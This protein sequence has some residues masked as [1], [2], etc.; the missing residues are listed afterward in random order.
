MLPY[1]RRTKLKIFSRFVQHTVVHIH[2]KLSV[3][4]LNGNTLPSHVF[5]S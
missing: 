4:H 1:A 3:R 2:D 5:I